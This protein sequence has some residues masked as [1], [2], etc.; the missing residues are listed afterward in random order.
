MLLAV[1]GEGDVSKTRVIK[2]MELG[3]EL[4]R[5]KGEVLLLAPMSAAAYNIGE[6]HRRVR[7][8]HCRKG[9]PFCSLTRLAWSVSPCSTPSISSATGFEQLGRTPLPSLVLSPSSLSWETS[10]SSHPSR[11]NRSGKHPK[12]PRASLGQLIW[13]RFT[14]VIIL[15]EKQTTRSSAPSFA[16]PVKG[17]K[18]LSLR[19]T[20]ASPPALQKP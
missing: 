19:P 10:T 13:R 17:L 4:L 14:D 9:G 18:V 5:R 16:R 8:P 11:P 12:N 7:S 15:D 1:A 2:A 3:F 20:P 6:R